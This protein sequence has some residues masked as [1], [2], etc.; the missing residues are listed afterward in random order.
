MPT[1]PLHQAIGRV[2][3]GVRS[4]LP[5]EEQAACILIKDPACVSG[6]APGCVRVPQN[7]PLFC[8]EKKGN[9][10][11]YCNVDALILL[12]GKIKVIVEIEESALDPTQVLGKFLA[13]AAAR[14]YIH[15]ADGGKPVL[16][17]DNVLFVQIMDTSSLK[18]ESA[19]R[20]QWRNIEASIRSLLPLG[21]VRRYSLFYGD[22]ND[23][24][25]DQAWAKDF[26]ECVTPVLRRQGEVT[27]SSS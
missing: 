7:I 19:K 24:V 20:A 8:S 22:E 11:E 15:N 9:D 12:A 3:D 18:P 21:S 10:T 1:H 4:S 27:E 5:T 14:Y 2:L 26:T 25:S 17:D 16:K 13:L 6:P 23:L